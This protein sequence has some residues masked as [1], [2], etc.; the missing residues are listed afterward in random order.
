M[1][2]DFNCKSFRRFVVASGLLALVPL[3]LMVLW[4]AVADPMH[5]FGHGLRTV[6]DYYLPNKGQLTVNNFEVL[7]P[8]HNFD[9]F[10]I[11]SSLCVAYRLDD[12][13]KYLPNDAC[14][15]HFDFSAMRVR[16]MR[17]AV[18]YLAQNATMRHALMVIDP[19]TLMWEGGTDN[20]PTLTPPA[21]SENPAEWLTTHYTYFSH[22]FSRANING[23]VA[24]LTGHP[25]F[26]D[27]RFPADKTIAIYDPVKN[28]ESDGSTDAEVEAAAREW[29]AANPLW[30]TSTPDWWASD[31]V[32]PPR[33]ADHEADFRRIAAVMDSLGTSYR[34]ILGPN[35][36]NIQMNP[37]DKEAL[38]EI[39]GTNFIDLS[40]SMAWITRV[41]A[42]YLD[43]FHYYPLVADSLMR[44]AYSR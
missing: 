11:G 19:V 41:P 39:F 43:G 37:A 8:T 15:Y 28:E 3:L 34:L 12:W 6:D 27:N 33:L 13:K 17:L 26:G 32:Y 24:E 5:L 18:D 44:A 20:L 16:Q 31:S 1:G 14:P 22:C 42:Y 9:S 29:M 36:D 38:R 23:F 2:R 30:R 35:H 7:N 40:S 4:Y 21:L 10:I 25:S